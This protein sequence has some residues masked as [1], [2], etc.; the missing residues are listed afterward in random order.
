VCQESLGC[1]AQLWSSA[2]YLNF[3]DVVMGG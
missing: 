1:E 3:F 2:M